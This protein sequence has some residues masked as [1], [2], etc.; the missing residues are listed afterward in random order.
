MATVTGVV[1]DAEGN[2]CSRRVFVHSRATGR[3]LGTAVS[4][5]TTGTYEI[6]AEEECYIVCLDST[7]SFNAK[8]VDGVDPTA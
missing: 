7:D 5:P 2:L 8:I 4:D 1:R 3:L 6:A